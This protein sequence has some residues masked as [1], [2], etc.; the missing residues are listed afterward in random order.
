MPIC[1]TLT[2]NTIGRHQSRMVRTRVASNL[3]PWLMH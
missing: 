3:S 2:Y 1:P